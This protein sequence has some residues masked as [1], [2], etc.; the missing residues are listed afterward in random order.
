MRAVIYCR[1]STKEQTKN[2]SLPTQLK[3]CR[4]YCE[5]QGYEVAREFT[6]AGES[7]KATKQA[8]EVA[9]IQLLET[10][11]PEAGYIRLFNALV[12]EAWNE[13]RGQTEQLRRTL[14]SRVRQLRER[15]DR[16]DEAFLHERSIDRQTYER[17]RDQL[18]E[19]LALAEL[20]LGDAVLDQVDVE[21]L[22]AFA[23]H[24]LTNA[25]R[26]WAELELD[27]K[28]QL[29]RVLFPEGL[30]FDGETFG[31]AVTCLAFTQLRPSTSSKNGVASPAGFE[32]AVSALKGQRVG[33]AT[34]WGRLGEAETG[35]S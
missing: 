8:L 27:Q 9:F 25:A 28:Q 26:L 30:R 12:L 17:Q 10:L 15:L 3:A 21:G 22:L 18:R 13:R 33:P 7:A 16:T 14:E 6:D 5:R 23:E 11:Q 24:L 1:V 32:P 19:Q 29:Q 35:R 31:T 20:E 2:L 4:D 34:P